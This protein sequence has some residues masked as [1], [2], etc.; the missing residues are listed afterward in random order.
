M[1]MISCQ[2]ASRLSSE[3]MD[4]ELLLSERLK[5]WLH[6]KVCG[7]CREYARHLALI[8]EASERLAHA[9]ESLKLLPEATLSHEAR[10]RIRL[11]LRA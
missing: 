8:K 6:R 2:E 7:M 5:L 4:R 10:E 1:V 9:M 3:A 11:S